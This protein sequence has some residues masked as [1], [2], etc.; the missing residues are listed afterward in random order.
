MQD[1]H[2]G[3]LST[4]LSPLMIFVVASPT[5]YELPEA[6][7]YKSSLSRMSRSF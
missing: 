7:F 4:A 1:E 5:P 6:P 3:V 2:V